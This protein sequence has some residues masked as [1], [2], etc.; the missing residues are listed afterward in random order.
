MLLKLFFSLLQILYINITREQ[1][2]FENSVFV[3]HIA[4]FLYESNEQAALKKNKK[5]NPHGT[6][7]APEKAIWISNSFGPGQLNVS[8]IA[9]T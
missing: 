7:P 1:K 8:L 2:A 9:I 5:K 4:L 6:M 3:C